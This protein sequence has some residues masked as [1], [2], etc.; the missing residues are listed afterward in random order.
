VYVNVRNVGVGMVGVCILCKFVSEE[1]GTRRV[2]S[3]KCHLCCHTHLDTS[4]SRTWQT[5]PV[6]VAI[7]DTP[8]ITDVSVYMR[9]GG[10]GRRF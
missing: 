10:R 2:W 8:V 1:G 4:V 7:T 9:E 6:W 5:L 3:Q